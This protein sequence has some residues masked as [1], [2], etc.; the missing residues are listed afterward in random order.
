MSYESFFCVDLYCFQF[1]PGYVDSQLNHWLL[2]NDLH[3]KD[4]CNGTER[5]RWGGPLGAP[6]YHDSWLHDHSYRGDIGFRDAPVMAD[7]APLMERAVVEGSQ[8]QGDELA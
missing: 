5:I 3:H 6:P 4:G 7:E 8:R 1:A 2:L